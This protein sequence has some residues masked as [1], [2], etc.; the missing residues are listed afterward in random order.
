MKV[1][2]KP[3]AKEVMKIEEVV[4]NQSKSN[5][6]S[7]PGVQTL[8][9]K[10]QE[11]V[12]FQEPCLSEEIDLKSSSIDKFKSQ[13]KIGI[14][15]NIASNQLGVCSE[16]STSSISRPQKKKTLSLSSPVENKELRIVPFK[17]EKLHDDQSD[18]TMDGQDVKSLSRP[19]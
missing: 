13:Q 9:R 14:S 17:L 15:E 4:V 10:C 5:S 6:L 11:I 3:Q 19:A 16:V 2:Q 7:E 12:I 18:R 8:E 1:K